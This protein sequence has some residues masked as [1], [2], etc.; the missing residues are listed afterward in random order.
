MKIN[1]A[2]FERY[3]DMKERSSVLSNYGMRETEEN[4]C[5]VKHSYTAG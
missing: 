4:E 5:L 3:F 1:L 2:W